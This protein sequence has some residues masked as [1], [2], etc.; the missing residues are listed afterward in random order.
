MTV[1]PLSSQKAVA[2]NFLLQIHSYNFFFLGNAMWHH[3]SDCHLHL[4]LNWWTQV[5]SP[6]TNC[7][8]KS[9]PLVSCWCKSS[10]ACFPFLFV[11]ICQYLWHRLTTDLRTAK[12]FSKCH[13]TVFMSGWGGVYNSSVVM[14]Q[15]PHTSLSICWL[16]SGLTA[17]QGQ[18][19]CGL[20]ESLLLLFEVRLSALPI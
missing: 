10:M 2:M 20:H 1:T 4:G 3:F 5:S 14:Q 9:S 18:Q 16:L 8:R 12:L 19:L 15:L 6:V 13:D 17:L 11:C 7:S